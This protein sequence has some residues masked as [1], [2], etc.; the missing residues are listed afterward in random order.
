MVKLL[1]LSDIHYLDNAEKLYAFLRKE[2][3]F[4]LDYLLITGITKHGDSGEFIRLRVLI[5]QLMQF[6]ELRPEQVLVQPC[7]EDLAQGTEAFSDNFYQPLLG[8]PYDAD[9]IAVVEMG[10]FQICSLPTASPADIQ[11]S[12]DQLDGLPAREEN[13][14]AIL[15]HEPPFVWPVPIDHFESMAQISLHGGVK[16]RLYNSK[17]LAVGIKDTLINHIVVDAISRS[18]QFTECT[19]AHD[20]WWIS[21]RDTIP[22]RKTN[23]TAT[24][25]PPSWEEPFIHISAQRNQGLSLVDYCKNHALDT[26]WFNEWSQW[27]DRFW[28][29]LLAPLLPLARYSTG[30]I[31]GM[32]IIRDR[33][34]SFWPFPGLI[35]VLK[36][37]L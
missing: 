21:A 30:M 29:G 7:R 3:L 6:F 23:R 8:Q 28:Q 37:R 26:A 5:E 1:H 12:M 31:L 17:W 33:P 11:G 4:Q 14:R 24:K 15:H 10:S 13:L 20:R 16:S 25:A 2:G 35:D 34:T 18:V 9:E 19:Y 27:Y 36:E 22:L 32:A